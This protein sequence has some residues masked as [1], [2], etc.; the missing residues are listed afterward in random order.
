M[1]SPLSTSTID[2]G[3]LAACSPSTPYRVPPF[4]PK[5]GNG[6]SR[7]GIAGRG[8]RVSGMPA[9]AVRV[10]MALP[11]PLGGGGEEVGDEPR[12]SRQVRTGFV[13]AVAKR[14]ARS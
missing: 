9:V 1:T 5:V 4:A 11:D 2:V 12:G 7:R 6:S 3:A 10:V 8:W 13:G 14:A